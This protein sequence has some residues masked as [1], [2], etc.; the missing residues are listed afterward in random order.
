ML[1]HTSSFI[2][3]CREWESSLPHD[4]V[5]ICRE[6]LR[7]KRIY[8]AVNTFSWMWLNSHLLGSASFWLQTPQWTP[9]WLIR[10]LIHGYGSFR[11][12]SSNGQHHSPKISYSIRL[13][14]FFHLTHFSGSLIPTDSKWLNIWKTTQHKKMVRFFSPLS[15]L[16]LS[17]L[18]T[19]R[20]QPRHN[21]NN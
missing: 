1:E 4:F 10:I 13:A 2:S 3:P 11:I 21:K 7:I 16:P 8:E 12:P 17:S 9:G 19:T 6:C 20:A 18:P 5:C 14:L 15:P